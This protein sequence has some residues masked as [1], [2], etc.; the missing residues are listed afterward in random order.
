[1]SSPLRTLCIVTRGDDVLLGFKK[2][3]FGAGRWNGFGGKLEPGEALEEAAHRELYEES[4]LI[5]NTLEHR[6]VIN[7]TFLNNLD[8]LNVHIFH[9]DNIAGEPQETDEMR[10]R[11]F[12]QDDIPYDLMWADDQ[13][14]LP[15]LLAGK[16]FRARFN[17]HDEHT[18]HSFS[19]DEVARISD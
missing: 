2:R 1:M 3:G 6:G 9:T 7:F 18:I 8:P 19:V 5:A 10:P 4:G 12:K 14:W 13:H 17:F 16:S 15:L 11:W